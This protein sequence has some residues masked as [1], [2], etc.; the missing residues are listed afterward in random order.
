MR[1]REFIALGGAAAA[2]PLAAPA[3]RL[4]S[5]F[6][7]GVLANEEYPLAACE[8]GYVISV[9]SRASPLNR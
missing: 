8:T 9:T 5:S 7:V 2:W 1:R 3:Q 6:R 4:N